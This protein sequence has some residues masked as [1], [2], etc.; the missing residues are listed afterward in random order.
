MGESQLEDARDGMLA[1]EARDLGASLGAHEPGTIDR[2]T[3][4][5]VLKVLVHPPDTAD[6]DGAVPRLVMLHDEFP[7][8]RHLWANVAPLTTTIDN[9]PRWR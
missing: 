4:G 7:N 5:L 8:V 6:R 1:D 9:C 2:L 3:G